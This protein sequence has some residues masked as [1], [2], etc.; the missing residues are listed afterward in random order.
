MQVGS[1]GGLIFRNMLLARPAA[2]DQGDA[3]GENVIQALALWPSVTGKAG[4]TVSGLLP[5]LFCH[6]RRVHVLKQNAEFAARNWP[7]KF[8]H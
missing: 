1:R 8:V 7:S 3:G 6:P 2:A 5:T 4:S